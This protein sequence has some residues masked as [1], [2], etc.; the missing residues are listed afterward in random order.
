MP[1][2]KTALTQALEEWEPSTTKE[3]KKMTGHNFTPTN[4]NTR[5]TF[6]YVRD[7][8]G[9]TAREVG[10]YMA[11]IG[12]KAH[13]SIAMMSAAVKNGIMRRDANNRYYATVPEY[14]PL[15]KITLKPRTPKE[16]K[17]PKKEEAPRVKVIEPT[18][19]PT[20]PLTAT[21]VIEH[22]KVGEAKLLYKELT[23]IFEE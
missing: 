10:K 15:K 19:E 11:S 18:P 1:D 12:Q 21:Y 8:P 7:N 5:I 20:H 14:I 16:V 22:I 17:A 23:R 3:E 6:N 2:L 13:S 9:L 4:N